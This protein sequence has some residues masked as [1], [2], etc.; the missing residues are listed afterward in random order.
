MATQKLEAHYGSDGTIALYVDGAL[1]KIG[2][3]PE[4]VNFVIE[5]LGIKQVYSDDF[6]LG[7]GTYQGAAKD[8][9]AIKA[10][11]QVT[12]ADQ[13]EELRDQAAELLRK[14]NELEGNTE[15]E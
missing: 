4:V 15:G 7:Q 3:Q 11:K 8:L 1:C 13:A 12:Y 2:P 10:Y 14:A 6:M 5:M 9:A